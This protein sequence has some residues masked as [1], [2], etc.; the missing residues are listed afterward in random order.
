MLQ[1]S[2]TA[3][4]GWQ[5]EEAS[6]LLRFS[7]GWIVK[8]FV[9]DCGFTAPGGDSVWPKH[10]WTHFHLNLGGIKG[11]VSSTHLC[12]KGDMPALTLLIS[13]LPFASAEILFSNKS[14]LHLLIVKSKC[15]RRCCLIDE[16]Y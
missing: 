1:V 11:A 8:A 4:M 12:E 13:F 10:C 16:K 9:K 5:C 15:L 2:L 14:C 3:R 7:G 6:F